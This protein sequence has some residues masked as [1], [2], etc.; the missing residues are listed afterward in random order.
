MKRELILALEP[1]RQQ[2]IDLFREQLPSLRLYVQR[3]IQ[4]NLNL[5]TKQLLQD[6][7]WIHKNPNNK[8]HSTPKDIPP[9]SPT[10]NIKTNILPQ[11]N[12]AH[13]NH[14]L[15]NITIHNFNLKLPNNII[16]MN[17]L[18]FCCFY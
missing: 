13:F 9:I 18:C 6:P 11:P 14:F 10:F 4:P 3:E 12:D 8:G 7:G 5:T 16:R 17:K 1:D 2:F 15:N